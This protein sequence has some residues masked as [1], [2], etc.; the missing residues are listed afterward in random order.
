MTACL[1]TFAPDDSPPSC[2]VHC[3]LRLVSQL[4][5]F[6]SCEERTGLV[7][8]SFRHFFHRGSCYVRSLSSVLNLSVFQVIVFYYTGL[9]LTVVE[10]NLQYLAFLRG[11]AVLVIETS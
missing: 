7:L 11:A 4:S 9:I 6:E 2:D 3:I 8:S 5:H 1:L 10:E